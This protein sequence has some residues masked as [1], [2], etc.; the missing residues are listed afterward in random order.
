MMKK[1]M[2][3]LTLLGLSALIIVISGML[4]HN[5]LFEI[6]LLVIAS[7]LLYSVL[8]YFASKYNKTS[9]IDQ[10]FHFFREYIMDSAKYF[11]PLIIAG[12]ASI[13]FQNPTNFTRLFYLHIL[14]VV[15]SI[16]YIFSLNGFRPANPF[17]QK[18][19]SKR[20]TDEQDN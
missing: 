15:Y 9:Q 17:S 6:L 5:T 19:K 18:E 7:S 13:I 4:L 10:T 11:V 1:I 14:V 12:I 8:Y 20:M 2:H 3:F 16:G